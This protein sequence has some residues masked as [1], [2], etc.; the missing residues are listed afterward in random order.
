MDFFDE[1]GDDDFQPFNGSELSNWFEQQ[2]E[3][4]EQLNYQIVDSISDAIN[5]DIEYAGFNWE[6]ESEMGKVEMGFIIPQE[7]FEN[8]VSK[9]FSYFRKQDN[10]D[11]QIE[12]WELLNKIKK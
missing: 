5:K 10:A 9:S 8:V 2:D 11:M 4:H 7:D 12:C 3:L 6:F 1:H